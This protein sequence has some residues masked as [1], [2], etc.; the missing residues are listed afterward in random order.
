MLLEWAEIDFEVMV[1]DADESFDEG[2]APELVAM[3]IAS[4]KSSCRRSNFRFTG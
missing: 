3:Q 1:S 4:K 2:L